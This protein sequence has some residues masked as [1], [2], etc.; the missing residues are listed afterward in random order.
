M[1]GRTESELLAAGIAYRVGHFPLAANARAIISGNPAGHVKLLIDAQ[2][3][4]VLGAHCIGAGSKDLIS[5]VAVAMGASA[6]SEDI[7]RTC[8]PYPTWAEAL[9]HAA[10]AAGGWTMHV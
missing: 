7:A 4:L 9:R 2:A 5:A 10:M 3:N 6:I 1:I 8:H